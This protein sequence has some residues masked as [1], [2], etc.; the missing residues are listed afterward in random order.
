ME[1]RVKQTNQKEESNSAYYIGIDIGGTKLAVSLFDI[2]SSTIAKREQ[3]ATGSQSDPVTAL[4]NAIE[5]A[6][7]W[8]EQQTESPC[9]V[10]VSVGGMFDI[11]TGCMKQAPHLPKWS[12]F[13]I[14]E[15]IQKQLNVP[16]FAENDANACALAEWKYGAGVGTQ[17]LIF[18]TFGTG[19]G[20]GLILDGKLYRG[21]S[22]LAGEIGAI[23][24]ADDGPSIRNKPG[25]LEGFASGAGIASYA[26]TLRAKNANSILP[27]HPS[28]KDVAQAALNN[29]PLAISIMNQCGTQLGKGLA[30]LIDL[31][32]PEM[33]ILGSIFARSESL[34]RPTME[35]AIAEEA[36][37]EAVAACRIV[38]AKLGDSI[39]DYAAATVAETN[40][41]SV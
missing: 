33:I 28:A 37:P 39:G 36:M 34:I 3:F 2:N 41:N 32:N 31:L 29:D 38:P 18:L 14:V 6:K 22:G 20:G 27:L 11:E 17:N 4:G 8:I 16:V 23:R 35:K 19:L 10:G 13:P 5:T 15:T 30:I 7:V 21:I 1:I 12:N 24:V 9:A 40:F 25:C 26:E